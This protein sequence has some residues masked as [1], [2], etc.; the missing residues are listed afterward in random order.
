MCLFFRVRH[1]HWDY[2]IGEHFNVILGNV[3]GR[4][5][6]KKVNKAGTE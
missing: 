3:H 4:E 6:L 1:G 5:A 2:F